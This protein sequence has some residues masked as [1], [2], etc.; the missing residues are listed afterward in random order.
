MT[1][2]LDYERYIRLNELESAIKK[3]KIFSYMTD[4]CWHSAITKSFDLAL[5]NI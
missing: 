2:T 1:I 3:E 5:E 4:I